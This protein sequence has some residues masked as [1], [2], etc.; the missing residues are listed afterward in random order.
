MSEG[1]GRPSPSGRRSGPAEAEGSL[2]RGTPG[3]AGS[4]PDNDGTVWDCQTGRARLARREG[5]REEPAVTSRKR[6]TGS[7]LVDVGR[8]A[9]RDSFQCEGS[10]F[11]SVDST[12][13]GGH[14]EGLRRSRGDA[15]GIPA[16]RRARRSACG[17]HGN[18]S[19]S[20]RVPACQAGVG[21]GSLPAVGH[22][23]GGGLVVVRGRES[24]PHGEGGQRVR[25]EVTGMSGVHR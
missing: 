24:R 3:R 25:N 17:E 22:E 15:V 14:G 6:C 8:G 11:R 2:T 23:R 12:G 4:S 9:A 1:G 19:W 18:R 7:N 20:S 16:G 13:R 10:T 21:T 5:V